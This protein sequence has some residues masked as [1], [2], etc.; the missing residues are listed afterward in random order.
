MIDKAF[1]K[2]GRSCRVTFALPADVQAQHAALL[3]E[4][5][6]WSAESHLLK[7]RKEG[8][9]STAVSLKPGQRYR[10]RYLLDGQRWQNDSQ[11][12]GDAPNEHGEED[13]LLQV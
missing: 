5:N 8:S 3:G 9:F 12:D 7:R 2:T 6:G 4:F 1:T 13:S 11:A 10:F